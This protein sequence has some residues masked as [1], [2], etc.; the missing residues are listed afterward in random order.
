MREPFNAKSM[1]NKACKHKNSYQFKIGDYV[2][3][4]KLSILEI[5]QLSLGLPLIR[6][7]DGEYLQVSCRPHTHLGCV[8][9]SEE[10]R[11]YT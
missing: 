10:L 1:V 5:F 7:E 11:K 6:F 4:T 8:F 3:N 9:H 2:Y